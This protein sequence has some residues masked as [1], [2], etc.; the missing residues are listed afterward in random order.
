MIAPFKIFLFSAISVIA[1]QNTASTSNIKTEELSEN[2]SI[3]SC[4]E[5]GCSGAYI[6]AEYI[7]GLDIAH[8]FSNKMANQVGK[9]LKELYQAG[10]YVKVD[11]ENIKMKTEGLDH[12][13]DVLYELSIPFMSVSDSCLATTAFDHR[14]GWGHSITEKSVL[15]TFKSKRKLE[16]KELKTPEGL[17]EFWIQWQHADWQSNCCN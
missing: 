16:Y 11:L 5:N 4:D 6:G 9:Y 3:I 7:N 14:G 1:C 12:T 17:Q 10:T 15:N 13:G 8:Q 2:P